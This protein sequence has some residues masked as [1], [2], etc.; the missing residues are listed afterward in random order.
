MNNSYFKTRINK[1]KVNIGKINS[2]LINRCLETNLIGGLS[3]LKKK[4]ELIFVA[5]GFSPN[6]IDQP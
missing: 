3:R 2:K 1:C 4:F 6:N 5:F